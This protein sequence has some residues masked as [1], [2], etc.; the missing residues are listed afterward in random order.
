MRSRYFLVFGYA[1]CFVYS[2]WFLFELQGL[3]RIWINMYFD[4]SKYNRGW[5]HQ[6]LLAGSLTYAVPLALLTL[7]Q[8]VA[9]VFLCRK[10]K[11]QEDKSE[12]Q[13]SS[14]VQLVFGLLLCAVF[15]FGTTF[16]STLSIKHYLVGRYEV[17]SQESKWEEKKKIV[18]AHKA[19]VFQ[20]KQKAKTAEYG[21]Y[22]TYYFL[23]FLVSLGVIRSSKRQSKK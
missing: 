23:G 13:T 15:M 12:D 2:M 7:L 3:T 8:V 21:L 9:L 5:S 17:L 16:F 14:R 6:D 20:N 1:V 4:I 10:W 19:E 22:S 18:R 11:R